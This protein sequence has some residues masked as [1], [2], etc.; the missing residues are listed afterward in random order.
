MNI[1]A[2]FLETRLRVAN[3]S[4]SEAPSSEAWCRIV[5]S[6]EVV[7]VWNAELENPEDLTPAVIVFLKSVPVCDYS[8]L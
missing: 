6:S 4:L 7:P 5:P 1:F 3:S 2:V 8:S